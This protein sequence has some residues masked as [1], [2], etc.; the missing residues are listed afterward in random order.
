[1]RRTETCRHCGSPVSYSGPI[2]TAP[3][4]CFHCPKSA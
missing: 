1:M 3:Q 2:D 4:R